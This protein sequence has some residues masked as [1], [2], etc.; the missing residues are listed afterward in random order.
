M[1]LRQL[2]KGALCP[3]TFLGILERNKKSGESMGKLKFNAF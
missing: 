1:N 2:T 3:C